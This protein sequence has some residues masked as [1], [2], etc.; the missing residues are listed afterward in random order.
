MKGVKM[1]KT[2]FSRVALAILSAAST[3]AIAAALYPP[4]KGDGLVTLMA[5]IIALLHA[6][7]LGIPA[8]IICQKHGWTQ[9]WIS[10][11]CG[12]IIG[13]V[14][15]CYLFLISAITSDNITITEVIADVTIEPGLFGVI[16]ALAAWAVWQ[17]PHRFAK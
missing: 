10:A 12:F 8:Y 4:F 14:P 1:Q 9:W 16:G 15:Y 11:L 7:T 3:V 5:F 2:S 13:T 6:Q 17:L